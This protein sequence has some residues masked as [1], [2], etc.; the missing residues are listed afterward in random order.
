[1][2]DLNNNSILGEFVIVNIPEKHLAFTNHVYLSATAHAQLA[3]RVKYDTYIQIKNMIFTARSH[4]SIVNN[5][6]GLGVRHRESIDVCNHKTCSVLASSPS[7]LLT[8]A[9][10][11]LDSLNTPKRCVNIRERDLVEFLKQNYKLQVLSKGQIIVVQYEGLYYN[12][13]VL[14]LHALTIDCD[15]EECDIATDQGI[16]MVGTDLQ[17]S[18]TEHKLIKFESS[19]HKRNSQLFDPNWKFED[20]GW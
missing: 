6:I 1:M 4:P 12:L 16:L 9:H 14:K 15:K 17:I 3:L 18:V 13:V 19:D 10:L 5:E 11:R 2:S 20:I 8:T 7:A